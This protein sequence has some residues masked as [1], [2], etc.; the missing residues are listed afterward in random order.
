L[1]FFSLPHPVSMGLKCCWCTHSAFLLPLSSC[2]FPSVVLGPWLEN[3]N[4][5][6]LIQE[7]FCR[8][9][10]QFPLQHSY[11]FMHCGLPF[12][13]RQFHVGG[14]SSASHSCSSGPL[15]QGKRLVVFPNP[16]SAACRQDQVFSFFLVSNCKV[17][18]FFVGQK[19]ISPF[20][21]QCFKFSP[22]PPFIDGLFFSLLFS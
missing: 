20:W 21:F 19:F 12:R 17:V 18:I 8:F 15:S 13:F 22:P 6:S 7:F 14:C 9:L 11:F 10:C 2:C 1:V 5:P 4:F 3:L 16:S